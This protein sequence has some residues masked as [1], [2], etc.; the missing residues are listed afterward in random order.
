PCPAADHPGTPNLYTEGFP[1]P[2][3]LARLTPVRQGPAAMELPDDDYPIVLNT[4]RVLYH[5]HGGT[6]TS[7]V[8]GLVDMVSEVEATIH[9]IDADTWGVL[10]GAQVRVTSRRGSIVCRAKLSTEVA[11]GELFMPFVSLQ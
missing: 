1:R 6:I 10:A 8:D 5:W 11:P 9:P 3:G 7:P 2:N 4:G